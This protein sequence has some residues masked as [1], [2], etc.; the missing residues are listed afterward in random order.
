M[1]EVLKSGAGTERARDA[2]AAT[3]IETFDLVRRFGDFTAVDSV[4]LR[5]RF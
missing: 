2:G 5:V 3:A 4:N 1:S